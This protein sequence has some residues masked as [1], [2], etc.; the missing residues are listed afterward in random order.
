M[1]IVQRIMMEHGELH[2]A[3]K[4]AIAH[5]DLSTEIKPVAFAVALLLTHHHI[6]REGIGSIITKIVAEQD[7]DV[8]TD[9]L[10]TWSTD[11][12]TIP[13]SVVNYGDYPVIAVFREKSD[14]TVYNVRRMVNSAPSAKF[15][16]DQFHRVDYA[17]VTRVCDNAERLVG[18]FGSYEGEYT[19]HFFQSECEPVD[20][21]E[22]LIDHALGVMTEYAYDLFEL[23]VISYISDLLYHT[24]SF[25]LC[26]RGIEAIKQE[27]LK[28]T[29]KGL[30]VGFN[31]TS[32]IPSTVHSISNYTSKSTTRT[33]DIEELL[34]RNWSTNRKIEVPDDEAGGF[35]RT[36][37]QEMFN[38][39]H[40]MHY[41]VTEWSQESLQDYITLGVYAGTLEADQRILLIQTLIKELVGQIITYGHPSGITPFDIVNVI[42]N[43]NTRGH[44]QV[45]GLI[46]LSHALVE[47]EHGD[48]IS[49][50]V[51]IVRGMLFGEMCAQLCKRREWMLLTYHR[52]CEIESD[53][54]KDLNQ[55]QTSWFYAHAYYSGLVVFVQKG[56]C[57]TELERMTM[58]LRHLTAFNIEALR[59]SPIP[60]QHPIRPL[61]RVLMHMINDMVIVQNCK[62]LDH[63]KTVGPDA[64]Q[65]FVVPPRQSHVMSTDIM[66]D[67]NTC[68][69]TYQRIMSY[70]N[71]I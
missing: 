28:P 55:M 41:G 54:V 56:T 71:D 65:S 50:E 10:T 16:N 33:R 19:Q 2:S 62:I 67:Y 47:L 53:L 68:M 66:Q 32:F 57:F 11:P 49:N 34:L 38:V 12:S 3:A 7:V 46:Y 35:D 39:F 36:H 13:V 22:L 15:I 25:L 60:D 51:A 42:L 63:N 5:V 20:I 1:S 59:H 4:Q 44:Y 43:T 9:H 21:T 30:L 24:G 14:G 45:N 31:R 23:D 52:L 40:V 69:F 29:G 17:F 18:N 64:Q 48:F 8:W 37:W 27:L 26:Y 61:K 58:F 6:T 70:L